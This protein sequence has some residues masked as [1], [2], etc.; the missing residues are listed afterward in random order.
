[1][2]EHLAEP[3][4][5]MNNITSILKPGGWL[6]CSLPNIS[7]LTAR[8]FGETWNCLLLEHLWYFDPKTLSRYLRRFRFEQIEVSEIW[9]PADVG[10]I[11]KRIEQTYGWNSFHVPKIIEN[12]VISLPI[13][14]MFGAYRW[15]G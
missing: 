11:F 7:S 14:L 8:L 3:D 2:V 12:R 5:I 6:F 13:G 10:S 4:A 1:M 9:Y 15:N